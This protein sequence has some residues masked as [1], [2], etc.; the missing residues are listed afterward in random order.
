MSSVSYSGCQAAEAPP[1][2]DGNAVNGSEFNSFDSPMP[3]KEVR[4]HPV[5]GSRKPSEALTAE[6]RPAL[7]T[8]RGRLSTCNFPACTARP[9]PPRCSR[10]GRR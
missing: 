1:L 4:S 10:P 3:A 8:R 2:L 6:V 5:R 7:A 9:C